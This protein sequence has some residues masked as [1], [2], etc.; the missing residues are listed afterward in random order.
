MST[1]APTMQP[2]SSLAAASRTSRPGGMRDAA[3]AS[4]APTKA[5]RKSD[6]DTCTDI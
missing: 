5:W 6:D 2:T 1:L 3:S 4:A